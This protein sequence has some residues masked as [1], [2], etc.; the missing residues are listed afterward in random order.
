MNDDTSTATTTGTTTTNSCN[1]TQRQT[2]GQ[3]EVALR[4]LAFGQESTEMLTSIHTIFDDTVQRA[5]SWLERLRVLNPMSYNSNNSNSIQLP[6]P[7]S[8]NNNA[9]D[10][11]SNKINDDDDEFYNVLLPPIRNLHISSS[12]STTTSQSG[13]PSS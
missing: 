1:V 13:I 12:T 2:K 8:N 5:E 4:L 6:P 7:L 3:E 10:T 9:A 11:T